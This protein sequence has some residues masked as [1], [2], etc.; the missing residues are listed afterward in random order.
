MAVTVSLQLAPGPATAQAADA[1][2][3]SVTHNQKSPDH[4]EAATDD[5]RSDTYTNFDSNRAH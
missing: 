4:Q 1:R 3:P 5:S 2:R